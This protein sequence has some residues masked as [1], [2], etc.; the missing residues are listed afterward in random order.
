MA[1]HP[2]ATA[3]LGFIQAVIGDVLQVFGFAG[4]T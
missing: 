3:T 2:V 4:H 1:H